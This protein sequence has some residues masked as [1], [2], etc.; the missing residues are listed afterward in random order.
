MQLRCLVVAGCAGVWEPAAPACG[1]RLRRASC[2][3]RGRGARLAAFQAFQ[4][5]QAFRLAAVLP[6]CA[7]SDGHSSLQLHHLVVARLRRRV[8][9]GCAGV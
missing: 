3:P 5:F 9:A 1:L 4:A 6:S 7:S 2:E 8:A